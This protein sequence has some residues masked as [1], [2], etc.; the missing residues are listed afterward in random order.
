MNKL[1]VLSLI[2]VCLVVPGCR[3]KEF[4]FPADA[5]NPWPHPVPSSPFFQVSPSDQSVKVGQSATFVSL[6]SG[7]G[8]LSYQWYRDNAP[9][10]GAQSA[11]Y[12]LPVAKL[13]DD[14]ARFRALVVDAHGSAW[15]L[16]AQ[17]K[18]QIWLADL[19]I[20]GIQAVLPEGPSLLPGGSLPL[21]IAATQASGPA[22]AT[23][24]RGGGKV[25][26]DNFTF[27]TEV[28]AVDAY[29]IVSLP[30]D[31][32]VSDGVLPHLH[33]SVVDRSDLAADLDIPVRY[34]GAFLCD[35]SGAAGAQGSSGSDGYSGFSGSMGS[36]DPDNPQAGGNGTD[37]GSG[38]SGGD[39]GPGA[40]GPDVQAWV[41]LHPGAVPRLE[42][43]VATQSQVR[44]FLV[45]PHGGSL[46][47]KGDGGAGGPG[48]NGGRGGAGGSGGYGCPNGSDGMSGSDGP[49]GSSGVGGPGG[50]ITV[51]VDP[52]ASPFLSTLHFSNKGGLPY[53][54][55]GPPPVI[56][57]TPVEPLW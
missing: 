13:E 16:P 12:I 23:E 28:V 52:A 18:V 56:H 51:W 26:W 14:G 47:L 10:Q 34:D 9:I 24:G 48:G 15:S 3:P 19:A 37:G 22:L 50:S 57:V 35:V 20:S 53:G 43:K 4:S 30:E 42:V 31:P 5:S 27:Q 38:G 33:A 21:V 49:G 25:G 7:V 1:A 8:S 44:Y 32:R 54:Q 41:C 36:C 46:L 2:A 17:L 55:D 45:D 11:T 6:A 39:G 40:P 29:G